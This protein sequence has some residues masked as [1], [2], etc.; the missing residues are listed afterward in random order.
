MSLTLSGSGDDTLLSWEE[1][2][3]A[4]SYCVERGD[5]VVLRATGGDFGSRDLE[6]LSAGDICVN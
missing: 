6:I 2:P 3:E 5:L 4:Q 1:K